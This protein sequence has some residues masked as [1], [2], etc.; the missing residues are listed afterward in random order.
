MNIS[1]RYLR[2]RADQGSDEHLIESI[3]N[4]YAFTSSDKDKLDEAIR[5]QSDDVIQ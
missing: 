1:R 3:S 4:V 2:S 5:R